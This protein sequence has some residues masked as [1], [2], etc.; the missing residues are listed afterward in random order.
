MVCQGDVLGQDRSVQVAAERIFVA[1]PLEAAFAVV[2]ESVCNSGKRLAAGA[3]VGPAAVVLEACEAATLPLRR[4]VAD[5]ALRPRA[6]V[7]RIEV[8]DAGP[9]HLRTVGAAV[10]AARKLIAAADAEEDDA[11]IH[12]LPQRRFR[13]REVGGNQRLVAV[14]GAAHEQQVEVVRPEDVARFQFGDLEVDV[15]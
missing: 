1:R 3:E 13:S 2:A 9:L 15:T 5:E 7:Q 14:L 4:Q 11:V 8:E 10:E 6:R 12:G